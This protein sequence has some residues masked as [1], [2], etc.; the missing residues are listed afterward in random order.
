VQAPVA[1]FVRIVPSQPAQHAQ[2]ISGHKA[3]SV[4]D[5][6]HIV[7]DTDLREAAERQAA[8]VTRETVTIE[9]RRRILESAA[10][11]VNPC[12]S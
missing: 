8:Y 12:I 5:R 6:Y 9:G 7:S 2:Q 1:N 4:F 3:R 11:K 10:C